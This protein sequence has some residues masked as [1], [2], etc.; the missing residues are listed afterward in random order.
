M[1]NLVAP[2]AIIFVNDDLVDQVKGVIQRQLYITET[3]FGTEFDARLLAD[4]N[5]P[6]AIHGNDIRLLVIRPFTETNNRDKADLVLFCKAGLASVLQSN[7]GPPGVTYSIDRMYL[8]QIFG[9][10][11]TF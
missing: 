3:I 10:S 5:Y 4:P 7:F 8:T 2:P 6:D 1:V 11:F 9:R